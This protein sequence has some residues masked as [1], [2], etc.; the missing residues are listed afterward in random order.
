MD[1]VNSYLDLTVNEYT[2]LGNNPCVSLLSIYKYDNYY[3]LHLMY[4]TNILKECMVKKSHY[5]KCK[6][7]A[8]IYEKINIYED[9]STSHTNTTNPLYI[10]DLCDIAIKIVKKFYL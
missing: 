1:G 5:K 8:I 9:F 6:C 3:L 2:N 10:N 7:N 4:S